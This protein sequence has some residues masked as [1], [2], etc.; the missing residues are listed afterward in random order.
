MKRA[1]IESL[2]IAFALTGSMCWGQT[3]NPGSGTVQIETGSLRGI[4]TNGVITFLAVPY[5]APPVGVLRWAAPKPARPWSGIRDAIK[6]GVA[7]AQGVAGRPNSNTNE[8]CL[9]LNITAPVTSAKRSP[10][11]VMVWLHGGG[12]S[13]GSSS[14]YD[15]H[16]MVSLGDVIVVTVEFR[17][18]IFGYFGHPGLDSSGTFG[19]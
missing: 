7:A 1:R 3:A 19:L 12:F 11:P 2:V 18:N 4:T 13:S 10:K 5:A 9:F 8:D 15:P 6:P 16:R 14:E 17:V